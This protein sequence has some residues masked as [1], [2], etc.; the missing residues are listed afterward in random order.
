MTLIHLAVQERSDPNSYLDA[1]S[2][3]SAD[4]FA[5]E[6]HGV[7]GVHSK[8]SFGLTIVLVVHH[9]HGLVG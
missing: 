5:S 4:A 2:S 7:A 3:L 8:A 9:S 1:G 6:F